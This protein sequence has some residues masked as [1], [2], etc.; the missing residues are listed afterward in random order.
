MK[1][2]ILAGGFG[3]R[4]SEETGI[5]P[6]PMVEIGGKP[7]LW[8]ILK[9][10][11]AHDVSEFII[12]CGYKGEQIKE[13]FSNYYLHMSDVTFD[14]ARREV[15]LHTNGC[16]PWRVTLV[17]TGENTMTGGRL[18]RVRE[19]VGDETFFFTYGDGV[20]DVDLT[21][22]REFHHRN[23]TAATLTA[24]QPPGRFGAFTLADGQTHVEQFREKPRGDA[25][26]AWVNGGFFVLEPSVFDHI[27]GD[28]T[29]W[30]RGPMEH[31]AHSRQ[32][33][34]YRHIGFWQ[35]MD[36][37]RDR[38]YLEETWASGKAPW[39]IW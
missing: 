26:G 39:K 27:D 38:I 5:K 37:L 12:C 16:E 10:F 28:S 2:V 7:I 3:T 18:K 17:D 19:Y 11:H 20:S 9:I 6:K 21:A 32:L 14:L 35:P 30:E 24:V 33:S 23:G 22:L 8:H 36:T 25:E 13:Y 31:L 29:V 4:L 34:A 1:A 15:S